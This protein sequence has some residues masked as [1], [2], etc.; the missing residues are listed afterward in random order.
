MELD[1]KDYLKPWKITSNDG[2]FEMDFQPLVDRKSKVN[3]LLIKS[4]Q[5]R[6]FG[7]FT[8]HLILDNGEKLKVKDFLGLTEDFY[9][10]W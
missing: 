4:D 1:P 5:H 7:S 3:F 9:N 2:R 6:V 8:G 10:R